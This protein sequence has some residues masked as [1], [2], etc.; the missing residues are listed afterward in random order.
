MTLGEFFSLLEQ[1]PAI[2]LFYFLAVPLS[3]LLGLVFGKGE[4]QDSPWKYFYCGIVYLTCV[5]GIF[6][7]TLIIYQFLFERIPIEDINI[8]TEI[9]PLVSMALTLYLVK[10]NVDLDKVPGFGKLSALFIIILFLLAFMWILDRT[11]IIIFT[12]FPF[13][14]VFIFLILA[15]ILIRYLLKKLAKSSE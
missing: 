9:I 7:I 13:Y 2:I 5:P 12:G 8:Y 3:A 11:R 10:K 14:Y 15:F 6:A 4:G 1:N